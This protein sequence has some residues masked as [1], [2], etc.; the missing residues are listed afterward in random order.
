MT[1][2]HPGD[3]RGSGRGRNPA[4]L[5]D[6]GASEGLVGCQPPGA[7]SRRRW[8]L[9]LIGLAALVL[10]PFALY[11][12]SVRQQVDALLR[13]GARRP[14]V[15]ALVMALLATDVFAPIPS[16]LVSTAS[17]L[18]LGWLPG[19]ACV[20]AGMQAGAVLG[21]GFGRTAGVAA[22]TRLVGDA[23]LAKASGWQ[24]RWGSAALIATRAIPVLAESSLVLAGA[25][26]MPVRRFLALVSASN[27][28]IA[29]VYAGLGAYAAEEQTFL[30]VFA[31]SI[32]IPGAGFWISRRLRTK[33]P[34]RT[35]QASGQSAR[36][37]S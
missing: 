34:S 29:L 26:R 30:W 6:R 16:S 21:Y 9:L 37:S 36:E 32:L 15:A 18:M 7:G 2:G 11:D 8:L 3:S 28:V 1:R 22:V 31:A 27:A 24:R 17:G 13:P 19:A 5:G 10:V 20:W 14:L 35:R 25:T 4:R 33:P 23:E 12:E